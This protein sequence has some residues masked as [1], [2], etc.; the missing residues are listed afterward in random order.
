VLYQLSYLSEVYFMPPFLRETS[1]FPF[2]KSGVMT[3]LDFGSFTIVICF[4]AL[5]LACFNTISQGC[6]LTGTSPFN[7]L[8]PDRTD[9]LLD[10]TEA[11]YQLSHEPFK[12]LPTINVSYVFNFT[13]VVATDLID[14]TY[15]GRRFQ[16]RESIALNGVV[17]FHTISVFLFELFEFTFLFVSKSAHCTIP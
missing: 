8:D 13:A 11:L 4:K 12:V 3:Y 1:S 14:R 7:G 16:I 2:L 5:I 15:A 6:F 9:G 10:V 17:G